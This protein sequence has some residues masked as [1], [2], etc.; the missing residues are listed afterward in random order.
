MK[1]TVAFT[2]MRPQKMPF[3]ENDFDRRYMIY[4]HK[5]REIINTLLDAGYTNYMSGMAQGFDTWAAEEV[6]AL[7]AGLEC[8]IPFPGQA[9]DWDHQS[10]IIRNQLISRSYKQTVISQNYKKGVYYQRN[11]YMVDNSEIVLCGFD[12]KTSGGTAYTYN[13]SLERGKTVIVFNPLN[14]KIAV[15]CKNQAITKL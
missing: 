3:A 11:R 14:Y 9:D 15:I 8:V 12:R 6:L 10:K 13:Y 5:L 2:G 4:R 1:H 7:G